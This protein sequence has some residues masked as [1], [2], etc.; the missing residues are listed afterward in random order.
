MQQ[1]LDQPLPPPSE[2]ENDKKSE[3]TPL[4]RYGITILL[5][6]AALLRLRSETMDALSLLKGGLLSSAQFLVAAVIF[7]LFRLWW[8]GGKLQANSALLLQILRS[9][10]DLI[11]LLGISQ[12]LLQRWY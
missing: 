3:V 10:T 12:L 7:V 1:P 9:A 11:I 2:P 5:F 8:R 6:P 4:L